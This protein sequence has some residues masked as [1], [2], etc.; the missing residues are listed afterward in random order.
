MD[1]I[2]ASGEGHDAALEA[3]RDELARAIVYTESAHGKAALAGQFLTTLEE[4]QKVAPPV[5]RKGTGL[6]NFVT[7]LRDKRGTGT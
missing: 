7:A 5:E 2:S 3:L 1:L 6:D 4:L